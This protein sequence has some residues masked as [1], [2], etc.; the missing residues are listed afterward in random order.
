MTTCCVR[1]K[2]IHVPVGAYMYSKI[3]WVRALRG[4]F[5]PPWGQK[6]EVALHK[7]LLI[8]LLEQRPKCKGL[9]LIR[10]LQL[11]W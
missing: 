7:F 8:S 3:K 11:L 5:G 10:L 2:L 1:L 9:V 6:I 4:Y